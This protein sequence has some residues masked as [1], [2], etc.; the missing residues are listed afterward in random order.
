MLFHFSFAHDSIFDPSIQYENIRSNRNLGTG[1]AMKSAD[2]EQDPG[3][4]S[5]AEVSASSSNQNGSP[6]SDKKTV[7]QRIKSIVWDTLDRS[8]EQRRFIAKIDFFI[9]T[10]ASLTYFSKNLNTN[11]LCTFDTCRDPPGIILRK[12]ELG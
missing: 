6:A 12:E 1:I 2:E 5:V 7:R 10:W 9:L 4:L 11:N 3:T 8:P